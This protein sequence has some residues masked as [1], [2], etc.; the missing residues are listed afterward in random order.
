MAGPET[1]KG[2][3]ED[4]RPANRDGGKVRADPRNLGRP[5]KT[6][7]QAEGEQQGRDRTETALGVRQ[8][9]VISASPVY[10]PRSQRP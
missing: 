6:Q 8:N 9:G 1:G 10:P 4:R 5:G 2:G 3:P 7:R